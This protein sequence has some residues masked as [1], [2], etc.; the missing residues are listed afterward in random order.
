MEHKYVFTLRITQK[1]RS[2]VAVDTGIVRGWGYGAKRN[3]A[4]NILVIEA[5]RAEAKTPRS[6][7]NL[8][9]GAWSQAIFEWTDDFSLRM[10]SLKGEEIFLRYF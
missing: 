10:A 2:G 9:C 5:S 3:V 4:K 7:H 6:L 8:K 1:E